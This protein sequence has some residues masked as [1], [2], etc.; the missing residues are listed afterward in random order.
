GPAAPT[1]RKHRRAPRLH[2]RRGIHPPRQHGA[3]R[4]MNNGTKNTPATGTELP[5][6]RAPRSGRNDMRH[7]SIEAEKSILTRCP[8]SGDSS[9]TLGMTHPIV[10]IST[11]GSLRPD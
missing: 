7:S 11:G 2:A 3:Q 9:T 10:V 5:P 6:L 4:A 1:E 8:R